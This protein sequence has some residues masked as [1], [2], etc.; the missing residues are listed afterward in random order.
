MSQ[1]TNKKNINLAF[2]QKSRE[3][4]ALMD[5]FAMPWT[6]YTNKREYEDISR[7]CP[8]CWD[9]PYKK[10]GSGFWVVVDGLPSSYLVVKFHVSGR[11]TKYNEKSVIKDF[12]KDYSE[13]S[14]SI[15]QNSCKEWACG[16]HYEICHINHGTA[17]LALAYFSLPCGL[18][19]TRCHVIKCPHTIL[20]YDNADLPGEGIV[21]EHYVFETNHI[22]DEL[23]IKPESLTGWKRRHYLTR[24]L[25][26]NQE[27]R[28]FIT[29]GDWY[30]DQ[31]LKRLKYT[32]NGTLANCDI[33][34]V[35]KEEH[36]D[37]WISKELKTADAL[38]CVNSP[39]LPKQK[40]WEGQKFI[41]YSLEVNYAP[42][43]FDILVTFKES[44]DVP[45]KFRKTWIPTLQAH[46]PVASYGTVYT[47]TQW[48][49]ECEGLPWFDLKNC[50]ISKYP[51]YLAIENS[52][53]QDYSTEKLWDTF[54]L[55]I[56]PVVWGAPNTRSYL[57][58]P[59]SAI[60]IEDFP[61][62]ESLA[63]YLKYLV[64]NETAYL[65]Y[66]QWRNLK[67]WPEEFEK[68]AYMSMWNMECNVCS[69]VA[70]LRVLKNL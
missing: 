27:V 2:P 33:P 48:D 36:P 22:L 25:N 39:N 43:P 32:N 49:P 42:G 38:F 10:F 34:C 20:G 65:E 66:H 15:A 7:T 56:V 63:N 62:V 30:T 1:K 47:N 6:L 9:K 11:V 61:N 54:N 53:V 28:I 17:C 45:T 52:Q 60:F 14:F 26:Q 58:H 24:D 46:I 35:W 29:R 64:G 13:K 59:K 69:E 44:S 23:T 57:P 21:W 55:G 31:D 41:E 51:F 4:V 67:T 3:M 18:T 50:V 12:S 40:G 68:K 5:R 19:E 37:N 8:T 16:Q 70:R